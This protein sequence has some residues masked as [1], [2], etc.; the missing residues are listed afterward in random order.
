MKSPTKFPSGILQ[1]FVV[2]FTLRNEM[3]R[4]HWHNN[5]CI[6]EK[7][8]NKKYLL[9]DKYDIYEKAVTFEGADFLVEYSRNSVKQKEST[10]RKSSR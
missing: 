4:G 9:D 10:V 2:P 7:C 3:I 8:V 5:I 1:E 6:F